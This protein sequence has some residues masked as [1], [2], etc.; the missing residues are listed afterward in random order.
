MINYSLKKA[1]KIVP[2]QTALA[3]M[4]AHAFTV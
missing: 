4:F 3:N 2:D 1:S